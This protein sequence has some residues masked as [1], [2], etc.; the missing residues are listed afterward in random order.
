MR[1]RIERDYFELKQEFGLSH[2]EGRG[3]P[4]FHHHA[5]PCIAAYSFLISER[6]TI[7]PQDVPAP[8]AD[9]NLPSPP[10]ITDPEDLL[11]RLR[12]YMLNRSPRCVSASHAPWFTFCRNASVADRRVNGRL[13]RLSDAVGLRH[14]TFILHA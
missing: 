14:A 8:G 3:W 11:L 10:T 7:P 5:S 12:R 6:E 2:Y 9:R 1:W 4:G 13:S